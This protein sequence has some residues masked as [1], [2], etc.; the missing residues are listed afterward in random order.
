MI[1]MTPEYMVDALPSQPLN[2]A[3][4]LWDNILEGATFTGTSERDGFEASNAKATDTN[5]WWWPAVAGTLTMTFAAPAVISAVGIGAH[6]LG[7]DNAGATLQG[8][9]GGVWVTLHPEIEPDDNEAIMLM[10]RRVTA[11]AIRITLDAAARI[12]VVYAGVELI[13]PQMVYTA[14]P[15]LRLVLSTAYETNKSQTGQFM[16]RSIIANARPFNPTW[17][18]LAEPWVRSEFYP[19][20]LGARR[21]PFFVALRPDGYPDDVGYVW[22]SGDIVPQRMGLKNFMQVQVTGEAHVGP[23]V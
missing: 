23:E 2:R 5:S 11:T 6:S 20:I 9:V 15:P 14:A 7:T 21:E 13:M 17:A 18:H 22:T 3:R 8:L 1:Y 10:F 19:F 16:G 4:I 12:G